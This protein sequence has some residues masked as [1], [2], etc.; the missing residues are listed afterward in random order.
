MPHQIVNGISVKRASDSRASGA[1]RT[2][3]YSSRLVSNEVCVRQSHAGVVG[4]FPLCSR[5]GS[6]APGLEFPGGWHCTT[7]ITGRG[8]HGFLAGHADLFRAGTY[9][10]RIVL[11]REF[12]DEWVATNV[13]KASAIDWGPPIGARR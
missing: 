9:M 1:A 3:R 2:K 10:C 4:G 6:S 12:A 5:T 11:A 8:E 13:L 7:E